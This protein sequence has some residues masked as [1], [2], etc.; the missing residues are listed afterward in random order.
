MTTATTARRSS[1]PPVR[2]VAFGSIE[3]QGH[4]I[5]LFGPGGVGKTTLAATAPGPVAFID[6]DDS[7]PIL[8]PSLGNLDGLACPSCMESPLRT[9][10]R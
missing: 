10:G 6:L 7:L 3:P 1:S 2:R 4:R 8:L 9:S 5:G